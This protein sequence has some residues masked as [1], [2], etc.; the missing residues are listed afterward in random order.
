MEA[1][2]IIGS[3]IVIGVWVYIAHEFRKVAALKGYDSIKYAVWVFLFGIIG[4]LL[5][6]ALPNKGNAIEQ[7]KPQVTDE[8]PEL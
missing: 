2:I 4:I 6:I 7:A 3:L 8:L 5:V 1:L